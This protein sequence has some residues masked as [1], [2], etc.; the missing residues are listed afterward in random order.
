MKIRYPINMISNNVEEIIS[1]VSGLLNANKVSKVSQ[2]AKIDDVY[3][4]GPY[5]LVKDLYAKYSDDQKTSLLILIDESLKSTRYENNKKIIANGVY[6]PSDY[7]K[8]C[9]FLMLYKRVDVLNGKPVLIS[10]NY[11]TPGELVVVPETSELFAVLFYNDGEVCQIPDDVQ[12]FCWYS[13]EEQNEP[14]DTYS[15]TYKINYEDEYAKNGFQDGEIITLNQPLF[16]YQE[17]EFSNQLMNWENP[18]IH[19]TPILSSDDAKELLKQLKLCNVWIRRTGEN[20][21]LY[22]QETFDIW[23]YSK[24]DDSPKIFKDLIAKLES[25]NLLKV[26]RKLTGMKV[27]ELR[28]VYAFHMRSN[29]FITK[30]ADSSLGGQLLVRFNWLL[31]SPTGRE[32]DLRFWKGENTDE[33]IT[34]YKAISNSATIFYLGDSTPHDLTPLPEDCDQDRYNLVITFG[35]YAN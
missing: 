2:G 28:E 6:L 8:N 4:I 11:L 30:H 23:E 3:F 35:D 34:R 20:N 33:P 1:N 13:E 7:E 5:N 18:I 31:Q 17:S 25:D 12:W 22:T 21:I 15:I 24:R 10:E 14:E 16:N 26:M 27:N 9:P 32:H 29:E 19:V